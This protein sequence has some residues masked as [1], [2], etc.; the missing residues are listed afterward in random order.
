MERIKMS[1]SIIS[2]DYLEKL[3][4][5]M[6]GLALRQEVIGR[7]IANV[8]TPGYHALTV[9]FESALKDASTSSV[10][11][12]VTHSQ[13]MQASNTGSDF[14]TS[15][16]TNNTVRADGNNVDIDQELTEMV[17]TGIRYQ[18]LAEFVG[19]KLSILKTIATGR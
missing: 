8:D 17:E 13:H 11:M 19:S 5:A 3:R 14:H 6:D 2:D 1:T 7:N 15:Q 9:D 4:I 16:R 12:N 10:T 18:A